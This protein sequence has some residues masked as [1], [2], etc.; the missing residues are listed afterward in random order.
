MASVKKRGDGFRVRWRDVAGKECSHQCPSRRIAL[1]VKREV[2][3][4]L[5]RRQDW[6]PAASVEGP[7]LADVVGAYLEELARDHADKTIT[8]YSVHLG[9]FHKWRKALGEDPP[10]LSCLRRDV[11]NA[12]HAHL[13]ARPVSERTAK[14]YIGTICGLWEWARDSDEYGEQA[15]EVRRPRI[16]PAPPCAT[17]PAATWAQVDAVIR[18]AASVPRWR[19]AVRLFTVLRFTGL[20]RWQANRLLWSDFDLQ[21]GTLFI[22]PALGKTQGEKR[23]RTVPVSPHLIAEIATWGKREGLLLPPV[24][25]GYLLTSHRIWR[26][27]GIPGAVWERRPFHALRRAFVSG[28]RGRE[29]DKD[30]VQ[31]LV[32][33]SLGVTGDVYTDPAA[34][35]P[36]LK[37]AVALIPKVD[38][39]GVIVPLRVV[40]TARVSVACPQ[41][42]SAV[43]RA[44][45]VR[46]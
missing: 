18:V 25:A 19:W 8:A 6:R 11:L 45:R 2:E 33:H 29:V 41:P 40:R 22:R 17:A 23:G 31:Y 42:S 12:Y 16:R 39:A 3:D 30:L 26:R 7:P 4:A 36:Q 35:W 13:L 5:A 43:R 21:A 46:L 27:A 32:G 1:E 28:L 38:G 10:R 24:P 20:R 44:T 37:A 15:A 14:F 34:V 9:A